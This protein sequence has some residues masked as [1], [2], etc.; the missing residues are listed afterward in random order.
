MVAY[1]DRTAFFGDYF[2][3]GGDP[4]E[5]PE[6]ALQALDSRLGGDSANLDQV[7]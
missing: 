3:I 1:S 6:S 5:N 7:W 2:R 4:D